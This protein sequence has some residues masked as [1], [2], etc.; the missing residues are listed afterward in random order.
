MD[1]LPPY[2]LKAAVAAS[3]AIYLV[4]ALPPRIYSASPSTTF[5]FYTALATAL[6]VLLVYLM[7]FVTGL[8]PEAPRLF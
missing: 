2:T 8:L 7:R 1:H 4:H 6:A 5:L 3:P